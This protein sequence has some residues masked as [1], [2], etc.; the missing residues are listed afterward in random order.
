MH[1]IKYSMLR[2]KTEKKKKN[3]RTALISTG[4]ELPYFASKFARK[5]TKPEQN[6]VQFEII[7][8]E[9]SV[10]FIIGTYICINFH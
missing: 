6:K 1:F 3:P 8:I 9:K 4:T 2:K 5:K 10:F 7:N